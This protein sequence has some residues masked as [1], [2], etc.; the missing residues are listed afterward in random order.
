MFKQALVAVVAT[1]VLVSPVLAGPYV[2]TEVESDFTGSEYDG[3]AVN[4]RVGYETE[5]GESAV[6]YIEIGPTVLLEDGA[7]EDTRLGLEVGGEVELTEELSLYGDVEML[8]GNT[9]YYGTT[10]GARWS[11]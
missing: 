2:Y 5:V 3:S 6:G 7:D 1:P 9:N 11:F 4:A 8:T 10:V